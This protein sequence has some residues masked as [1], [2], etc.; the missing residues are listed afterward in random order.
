MP[1]TGPH[2]GDWAAVWTVAFGLNLLLPVVALAGGD[3]FGDGVGV[4]AGF[5][6]LWCV[7]LGVTFAGGP[8]RDA[9][10]RGT[11]AVAVLQ[12]MPFLHAA[13]HWSAVAAWRRVDGGGGE[14]EAFALTVLTGVPL[15]ANAAVI[16]AGLHAWREYRGRRRGGEFAPDDREDAE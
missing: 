12:F 2:L 5:F 11:V 16:G 15:L 6:A 13:A 4:L 7:G 9:F 1:R 8:A 10:L 3:G 14:R